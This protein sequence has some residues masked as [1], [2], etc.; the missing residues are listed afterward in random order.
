MYFPFLYHFLHHW[1]KPCNKAG[2]VFL[3]LQRTPALMWGKGLFH[4]LQKGSGSNSKMEGTDFGIWSLLY[5]NGATRHPPLTRRKKYKGTH[6]HNELNS[7]LTACCI[8]AAQQ[9][10]FNAH[11]LHV[12]VAV[13][14]WGCLH[15]AMTKLSPLAH[16]Q[17]ITIGNWEDGLPMMSSLCSQS[18]YQVIGN[19]SYRTQVL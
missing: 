1:G 4:M 14:F 10:S 16:S 17:L 6:G 19:L 7:L 3:V 12:C 8:Y 5:N 18:Q 13:L 15:R 9:V 2:K 11:V